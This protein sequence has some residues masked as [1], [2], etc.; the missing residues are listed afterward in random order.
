MTA[1]PSD[2]RARALCGPTEGWCDATTS[3]ATEWVD[4]S[5][6]A[7]K[8][9]R[10][11]A[12]TVNHYVA[13]VATGATAMDVDAATVGTVGVP[14]TIYF[15]GGQSHAMFVPK[16]KPYL[17]YRAVTGTGVLRATLA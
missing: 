1:R 17:A 16:E 5:R 10:I 3:T 15:A 13:F 7:G 8:L 4:L 2:V 14:M 9:I 12:E 6:W 11:E